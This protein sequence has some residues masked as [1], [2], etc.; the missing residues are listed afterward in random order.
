MQANMRE[1]DFILLKSIL[2][3]LSDTTHLF[4]LFWLSPVS[5]L[6][7]G[8]GGN[9]PLTLLNPWLYRKSLS[10]REDL[11]K[12]VNFLNSVLI[13]VC[14]TNQILF[15]M[16]HIWVWISAVLFWHQLTFLCIS[17]L[18]NWEG[19]FTTGHIWCTSPDELPCLLSL[20]SVHLTTPCAHCCPNSFPL[21]SSPWTFKYVFLSTPRS[22]PM[23]MFFFPF[24]LSHF[25]CFQPQVYVW[26]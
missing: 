10:C 20:L 1:S 14:S 8:L 5:W 21:F 4:S 25:V 26:L 9:N 2:L 11:C 17:S 24:L 6:K 18:I 22:L 19:V 13:S 12:G 15:F 3:L 7:T 23:I 16:Q